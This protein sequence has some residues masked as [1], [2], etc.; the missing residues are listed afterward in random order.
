MNTDVWA[1]ENITGNM[2]LLIVHFVVGFAVLGLIEMR[3]CLS[4]SKWSC[5]KVPRAKSSEELGLDD[6]VEGEKVRCEEQTFDLDK[7]E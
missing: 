5:K 1:L 2:L 3:L 4:C 7:G 6:D